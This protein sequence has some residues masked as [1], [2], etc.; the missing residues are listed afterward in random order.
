MVIETY[1]EL[2]AMARSE[3]WLMDNRKPVTLG[4]IRGYYDQHFIG[5]DYLT[6]AYRPYSMAWTDYCAGVKTAVAEIQIE[7]KMNRMFGSWNSS[8]IHYNGVNR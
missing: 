4:W 2:Y 6:T 8:D 7:A 1:D 3:G 5:T